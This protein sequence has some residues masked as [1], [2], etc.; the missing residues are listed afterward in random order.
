MEKKKEPFRFLTEPVERF[1]AEMHARNWSEHTITGYRY[2]LQWFVNYL[3]EHHAEVTTIAEITREVIAAFQLWM[4]QRETSRGTAFSPS[5]Q[6]ATLAAVKSFFD[7]S[8]SER[9]VLLD[10]TRAAELPKVG[11]RLPRGVLSANEMRRLMR[12]P[13]L[14]TCSGL[15]DRAI[16]ETLYST[17]VRNAE[18]RRLTLPDVDLERGYIVVINGKNKKDRVVPLGKVAVHFIREYLTKAR[19]KLLRDNKEQTVF[20]TLQGRPLAANTLE[21]IVST[22]GDRAQIG[23]R[24]FPHGIRHTCATAML[25]GKADIRFIQEMLGHES[26]SSTQIYTH[27]EIGDLKRVHSRA[28][29]REQDLPADAEWDR[30]ER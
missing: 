6:R 11:R 26:L 3:T 9:I 21:T 22:H 25:K 2:R 28:H 19:P 30:T 24:V 14:D 13:D 5:S 16:L 10:P 4:C 17:G 1:T 29:P 7:F 18:L 23:R 27:V 12:Q 15:R 8:T 20:L